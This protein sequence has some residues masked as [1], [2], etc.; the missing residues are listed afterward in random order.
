M[1]LLKVHFKVIYFELKKTNLIELKPIEIQSFLSYQ[2]DFF[3]VKLIDA[4]IQ[5]ILTSCQKTI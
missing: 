4:L 3:T 1:Q 2:I 5:N